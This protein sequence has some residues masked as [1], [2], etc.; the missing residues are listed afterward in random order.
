MLRFLDIKQARMTLISTLPSIAT[1][2][3]VGCFIVIL[4]VMVGEFYGEIIAIISGWL[5]A[6]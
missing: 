4:V 6:D 1:P 5:D 3:A 2:I